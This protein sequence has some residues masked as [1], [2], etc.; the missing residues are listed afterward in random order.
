MGQ[1]VLGVMLGCKLP[2][3]LPKSFFDEMGESVIDSWN[4]GLLAPDRRRVEQVEDSMVVGI[5]V[6]C[7]HGNEKGVPDIARPENIA[8]LMRS[9]SYKIA[10]ENWQKF[11][12]WAL[13]K[14]GM[15]LPAPQLWLAPTEVA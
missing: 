13:K 9:H 5:W 7:S 10:A 12:V 8:D 1:M 11:A 4:S 6:V 15:K 14:G 2:K 3:K